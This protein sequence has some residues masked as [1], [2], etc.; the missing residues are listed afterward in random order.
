M[1]SVL[2]VFQSAEE[3]DFHVPDNTLGFTQKPRGPS[4]SL[5]PGPGAVSAPAAG[6]PAHAAEPQL[7]TFLP[8]FPFSDLTTFCL[9]AVVQ[10]QSPVS[11]LY[12]GEVSGPPVFTKVSLWKNIFFFQDH[13]SVTDSAVL[14][15]SFCQFLIWQKGFVLICPF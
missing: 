11:S 1:S 7:Q 10:M 6:Q 12:G 4:A 14:V 9:S 5:H 15:K 13:L 3:D 8:R 2:F